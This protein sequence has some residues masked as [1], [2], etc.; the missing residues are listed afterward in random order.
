MD[1]AV[2]IL[3]TVLFLSGLE[4]KRWREGRKTAHYRVRTFPVFPADSELD[5]GPGSDKVAVVGHP[6]GDAQVGRASQYHARLTHL[7]GS[8]P[9]IRQVP[10]NQGHGEPW[11]GDVML[12]L[13]GSGGDSNALCLQGMGLSHWMVRVSDDL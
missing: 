9:T 13:C 10:C 4:A 7:P 11:R 5:P 8:A 1:T 12:A 2:E 3:G 6:C